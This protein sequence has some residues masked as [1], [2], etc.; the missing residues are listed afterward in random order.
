MSSID[1][2]EVDCLIEGSLNEDT[3]SLPS[4]KSDHLRESDL[5][6]G[7]RLGD[8]DAFAR[9]V[10][11]YLKLFTLGI[12]RVLQDDFDTQQALRKALYSI[13]ME[14]QRTGSSRFPTWAYRIC[15]NEALMLRHF[16]ATHPRFELTAS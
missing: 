16:R 10:R 2:V 8:S 1:A 14:L 7:T 4:P 3:V 11:P 6:A 12:H 13:H 9:L 5:F 15:L